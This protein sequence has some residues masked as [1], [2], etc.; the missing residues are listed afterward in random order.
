[1]AGFFIK[2]NAELLA[3]RGLEPGGKAQMFL[4]AQVV[5]ATEPYV[6]M[7]EGNLKKALG[8]AYGSGE[9]RYN[10]PYAHYQLH[11]GRNPGTSIHG[12][13]RGRKFWDRMKSDKKEQLLQMLAKM[14]GG[15][16]GK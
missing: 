7:D 15:K 12:A 1:M 4:D 2:S 14:V 13:L 3:A 10:L 5:K 8:T 16:A 9:V 11:H 6:P